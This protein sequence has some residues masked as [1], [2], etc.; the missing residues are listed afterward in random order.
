MKS[1][2]FKKIVKVVPELNHA[3][4]LELDHE[5]LAADDLKKVCNLLEKRIDENPVCP[6]CNESTIVKHGFRS[7]LIRYRCKSCGKTFNAVTHTPLAGLHKKELW[8]NYAKCLIESTTIRAAAVINRISIRT[9]FNWRHRL[10]SKAQETEVQFLSGVVEAEEVF[11]LES[12]KGSHQ[13]AIQPKRLV[14]V[15]IACDRNGHEADYITGFGSMEATW[16]NTNFTRHLHQQVLF[17]TDANTSF[18]SFAKHQHLAHVS[19]D[20]KKGIMKRGI[21]HIQHA[22]AYLALLMHW[23]KRFHGVATKY[24]KN[25]LG[26][27]NELFIRKVV[28]PLELI[29]IVFEGKTPIGDT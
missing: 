16:L 14:S 12:F 29:S 26:W 3:Q 8:I 5:L 6:Y 2:K 20:T 9:S 22:D 10:M 27:C 21:C 19:L 15:L 18:K 11:F 7:N 25:Y 17:I 24:L 1:S 28:S 4:C 23:L 13:K